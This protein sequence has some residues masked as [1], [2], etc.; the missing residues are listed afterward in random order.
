[1]T[2]SQLIL[3]CSGGLL[4][5]SCLTLATSWTVTCQV[6]LF[7]GFPRQEY[8][9]RLPFGIF[10]TQ[11]RN[12]G[13]L[14]NRQIL[15]RLSYTGFQFSHSVMSNSLWPQGL[16]HT[17]LPCPSPTPAACSNLCLLSQWCHPSISSSVPPSSPAFN[18]SQHQGLFQ[19][20]SSLHQMAKILEFQHQSF[21]WI[22]RVDFL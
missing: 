20:V 4:G 16:Q 13:L 10:Q 2:S 3:W 8:W 19:W 21:Q 17:R 6:P 9:S 12:P 7:M 14:N 18:L 15:Y 5:K 1:M 11:E 22:F